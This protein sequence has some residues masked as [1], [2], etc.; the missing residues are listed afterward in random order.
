[1][2]RGV[3]LA[4]NHQHK[5]FKQ[6]NQ[7]FGTGQVGMRSPVRSYALVLGGRDVTPPSKHQNTKLNFTFL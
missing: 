5:M 1:M 7:N 3:A 6:F 4:T 2:G